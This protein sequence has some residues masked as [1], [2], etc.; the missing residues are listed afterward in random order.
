[1]T[2]QA[3]GKRKFEASTPSATG[4]LRIRLD[5]VSLGLERNYLG[6][7]K[8]AYDGINAL[9]LLA[10]ERHPAAVRSASSRLLHGH[11]LLR[12][13]RLTCRHHATRTRMSL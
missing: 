5:T 13:L 10:S 12:A 1:M 8:R 7:V 2:P 6:P 11:R 9:A 3:R 4:E